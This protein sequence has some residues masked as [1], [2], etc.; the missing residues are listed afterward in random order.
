MTT[1]TAPTSPAAPT[2]LAAP[3]LAFVML[4]VTDF[5]AASRYYTDTLGFTPMLDQDAPGFRMF[6]PVNGGIPLLIAQA[7]P[8]TAAAGTVELY[9]STDDLEAQRAAYAS[10]GAAVSEIIT[11]PFGTL[12]TVPA[13]DGEPLYIM[14]PP[15]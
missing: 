4:H 9:F 3:V 11:K 13:L 15:Q 14:R 12:F 8:E 10:Q 5:D 7:T 2:A 6:A 1:T